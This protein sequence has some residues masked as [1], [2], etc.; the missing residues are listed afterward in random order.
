MLK[1]SAILLAAGL[2]RRMGQDK[3]LLDYKGKSLF[4]HSIDLLSVL[5]VFER[6]VI[7]TGARLE[8][9]T[10][11]PGIRS[12]I[13]HTPESGQSGSI[14]TGVEAA[15]GTHYLFLNAD[16]PKL[17]PYDII[18]LL[19]AAKLHPDKIIF[20]VIDLKPNSPTVFPNQFRSEL[21]DLSG[22]TGGREIRKTNQDKCFSVE[23]ECPENFKD[24]DIMEEY[25]DLF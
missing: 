17:K 3:L 20:P 12:C 14:R 8:C 13:N 9:I 6:I 19:E 25:N 15:T 1:V 16:Q 21:L 24:I 5:P 22:D 4:Q 11:P 10:L 2:S 23:P 7:S 18:P